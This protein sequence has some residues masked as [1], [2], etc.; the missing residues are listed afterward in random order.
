MIIHLVRSGGFGGIRREVRIETLSLTR[1]EREP[2]ERMVGE[3]G[4]FTLPEKFPR[5]ARGADFFIY[6]ITVDDGNRRHTVEVAQPSV[7][8]GLRPL[9]RELSRRLKS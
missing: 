5:P 4:F 9:V 7:P 6:T 3:T 1:E 8:E 2:L